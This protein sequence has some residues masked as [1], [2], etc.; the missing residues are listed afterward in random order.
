MPSPH[1]HPWLVGSL[2]DGNSCFHYGNKIPV[3]GESKVNLIPILLCMSILTYL[4]SAWR[5]DY[6]ICNSAWHLEILYEYQLLLV[7]ALYWRINKIIMY[8][9][10]LAE[11]L[12][13]SNELKMLFYYYHHYFICLVAMLCFEESKN[14]SIPNQ[15]KKYMH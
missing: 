2:E 7:V 1:P 13:H 14:Q 15:T 11:C 4:W 3:S 9:K 10:C 8:M 12:S 6:N 5:V